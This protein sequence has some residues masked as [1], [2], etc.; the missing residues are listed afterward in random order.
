LWLD[1]NFRALQGVENDSSYGWVNVGVDTGS[2]NAY[3]VTNGSP[4]QSYRT[5]AHL[6]FIPANSNTGASTVN[7]D[8]LGSASILNPAGQPLTTGALVAGRLAAMLYSGS[9]FY[10]TTPTPFNYS[11]T[12]STN[13]TLNAAGA[14]RVSAYVALSATPITVT[15]QNVAWGVP[16]NIALTNVGGTT[17]TATLIVTATSGAAYNWNV[18]VAGGSFVNASGSYAISIPTGGGFIWQVSPALNNSMVGIL[19]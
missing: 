2:A 7:V 4:Y 15:V 13:T 18:K 1:Q 17:I 11:N 19:A 5:G 6:A 14:D 8:G 16:C 12:V 3:V 9:S 10:L